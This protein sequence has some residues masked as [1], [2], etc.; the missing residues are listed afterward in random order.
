MLQLDFSVFPVLE[1]E[2]LLLRRLAPADVDDIT[3]LRSN[4]QVN[5]FLGR[6]KSTTKEETIQF[7]EKI[8]KGINDNVSIYWVIAEKENGKPIG[9][10]CIW[11][12]D[13]EKGTAETGYELLP[14]FQGKGI[15]QEA[16]A[17]VLEFAFT[18]M[19]LEILEAYTHPANTRSSLLLE[20]FNFER[21]HE[22]AE[23]GE[24][25]FSLNNPYS[26]T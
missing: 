21:K 6:P 12:I 26:K 11:N 1:T 17:K 2:R 16:L 5:E 13:K 25:G 10:I 3:A 9:T 23:T 8:N 4:D 22:P 7:I 18:K 14:S 19:K 15:M 20:K 24:V